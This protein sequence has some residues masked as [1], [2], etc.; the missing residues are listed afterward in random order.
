MGKPTARFSMD[1]CG[2]GNSLVDVKP[3][4]DVSD[5]ARLQLFIEAVTDYA[6]YM[7]DP[8]GFVA[9]WNSGAQRI[10]G[11]AAHEIIGQHFSR[12]YTDADRAG[13]IPA[14]AL[15]TASETGRY[16]AEGWRLRKDGSRFWASVVIDAIRDQHG[17]L[18]GFAKITRDISERREAQAALQR[19]QEQLSYAQKM[20]ALGQLTGGVA[21]DFNNL[22]MIVS[23][24]A[25]II[26]K[27]LANDA[28]GLQAVEA[29]ES[30][31]KRGEILTRQLLTFSRRQRLNPIPVNL[32][33]RIDA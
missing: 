20:D 12:F 11:Y 14:Q 29:I 21:H 19:A 6:I 2:L 22:L 31:A 27:L 15:R 1:P 17:V 24:H 8:Q 13:G 10:K 25:R 7:L 9:S 23:G 3:L 28:R 33:E 18:I 16:E 26:K 5:A 30:A 4:G 32:A